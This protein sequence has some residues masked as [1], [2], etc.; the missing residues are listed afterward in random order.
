M[1][2]R[3]EHRLQRVIGLGREKHAINA[4]ENLDIC[5]RVRDIM[6]LPCII[7]YYCLLRKVG[8][9]YRNSYKVK[10]QNGVAWS[11][12]S[13]RLLQDGVLVISGRSTCYIRTEYLLF[14]DGVLV[15]SGRSTCYFRTEYLLFQDGVPVSTTWLV[16][17]SD[18]GCYDRMRN[19]SDMVQHEW[20]GVT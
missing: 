6:R 3:R 19:M 10:S 5:K 7:L 4:I 18:R 8:I 16:P 9:L 14:Q 11:E 13:P 12:R 2:E 17:S 1:H 15:I 20:H